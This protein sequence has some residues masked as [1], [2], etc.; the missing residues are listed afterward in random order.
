MM[1]D[2]VNYK[3]YSCKAALV[4]RNMIQHLYLHPALPFPHIEQLARRLQLTQEA[5]GRPACYCQ[6]QLVS[7]PPSLDP[8]KKAESRQAYNT[9]RASPVQI[10]LT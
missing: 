7:T 9:E 2:A 10:R 1:S 8:S 5:G 3:I 6:E 4:Q